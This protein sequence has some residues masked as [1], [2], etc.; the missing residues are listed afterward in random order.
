MTGIN[1]ND[2]EL[3]KFMSLA[4]EMGIRVLLFHGDNWREAVAN[5]AALPATGN[6]LGDI[7][8]ALDTGVPYRWTGSAWVIWVSSWGSPTWGTIAGTLS[9][10]TDLQSALDAKMW[11]WAYVLT[12]RDSLLV[13]QVNLWALTTGILKQTVSAGVSTITILTDNSSN[14]NSAYTHSQIVTGNPHGTTPTDLWL[15]NVNNTSDANK[16]VSTAQQTALNLK[17]DTSGKDASGGYVGLTLFKINFKNVANTIISFFTNSNTVARTYTFQDRDGTIADNTDL[18]LKAN[19]ASPTFTGTVTVPTPSND[20]DA[21]TKLYVDTVAQGLTAKPS[22]KLGTTAALP[23][24]TYNNGASGFGATL[25][26]TVVGIL[27]IDGTA[28]ALNDYILVKDEVAGANNGL[29]KCTIA[30]TAGV[31]YVLT[32]AIEMNTTGEFAWAYVFVE[33]GT[34]N[35]GNGWVCTNTS[36]PTVGT[37][38]ITFTQFSGAG[39]VIAGNGLS[40]SWNTLSIDTAVTASLSAVQTFGTGIKTFLSGFFALRN[41]AN[42]FSIFF[43]NTATANR[44]VT[45]RDSDGTMAYTSDFS[46]SNTGDETTTRI[47]SLINGASAKTTPVD[48]DMFG[49]MDSAASNI[50]TKLSWL[51][52]KAT[53]LTYLQSFTIKQ[54]LAQGMMHNGKIVPSVS[55]NNIT[56]ALKTA[57]WV[58][59]SVTDPIYIRIGDVVRTVTAALSVTKN[60]GTNWFNAGSTELATF[61]IDYFA[62]LGYNSTDW[63]VIGFARIPWATR[64][65]DFS[66]T[67]TNEKYCAISNITTA[68]STDYYELIGRFEA[69]LW[70]TATF[71]W[72][73]PTYQADTLRQH[74]IYETR[75]LAWLPTFTW[76]STNPVWS[77]AYKISRTECWMNFRDTTKGTSNSVSTAYTMPFS[78]YTIQGVSKQ[79]QACKGT[80]N[81]TPVSN[82]CLMETNAP[83]S[84]VMT[85]YTNF[86]NAA[87]TASGTKGITWGIL[88]INI[89]G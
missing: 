21:S 70:A 77:Y 68:W 2:A 55:G 17:Q 26:A 23:T 34:I 9:S 27:T 10:Q 86:G 83:I 46:G 30:G 31:A 45:L 4:G 40:K 67:T 43:S 24:N 85:L 57:A 61:A 81:T 66:T 64:Y 33:S 6:T 79:Y 41:V 36:A 54:T 50:L 19:L 16:P 25:T 44:T 14:W 47:G 78:N 71:N 84:N 48:A 13:N 52:L 58:D 65:S 62:Y 63:V 89:V 11:V 1:I 5:L 53:M 20:T 3:A 51:N 32:R 73:V 38:A 74:P 87:W 75:V 49:L 88:T 69:T 56:L 29:Y 72:S 76:F 59:P 60:A 28:V 42:T 82:P 39:L 37:T 35:A 7:R 15:G 80:D 8:Q 22:A 18:A 12:S